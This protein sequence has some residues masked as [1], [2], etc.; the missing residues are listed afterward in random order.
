MKNPEKI[1]YVQQL[2]DTQ[3]KSDCSRL[4]SSTQI[5]SGFGASTSWLAKSFLNATTD[6][7]PFQ[8][9]LHDNPWLYGP[10]DNSSWAYCESEDITCYILPLCKCDRQ[11]VAHGAPTR[12]F[13]RFSSEPNKFNKEGDLKFQ[14]LREFMLR[15]NQIF[16]REKLRMLSSIALPQPCTT[17]H[18]RRGDSGLP[19]PPFRR[20][21]AVQEYID[22]AEVQE[23]DTI[24][25]LTDDQST[26]DEIHQ[27]HKNYNWVYVNRTRVHGVDGGWES[28]LPSGD[29]PFEVL[30]IETETY[31]AGLCEK[32]VHGECHLAEEH[33]CCV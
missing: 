9:L 18:V 33:F 3:W 28:H 17:M 14:W 32:V 23:G 1:K 4:V 11:F 13:P 26:I 24:L 29:A 20:Y 8:I 31:L 12:N 27:Y 21:A 25:L 2:Y 16:R 19:R 7:N 15:P 30:V 5:D 10:T 6:G 22:L